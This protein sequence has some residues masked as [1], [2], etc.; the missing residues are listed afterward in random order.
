[1]GGSWGTYG[2]GGAEGTSGVGVEGGGDTDEPGEP[3]YNLNTCTLTSFRTNSHIDVHTK[4][5][6]RVYEH[7]YATIIQVQEVFCSDYR[8][9]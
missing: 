5:Y 8:M 6:F 3:T 7:E 1:M 2:V 4:H 9:Y